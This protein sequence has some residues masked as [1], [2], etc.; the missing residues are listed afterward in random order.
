MAELRSDLGWSTPDQVLVRGR[1]LAADVLGRRSFAWT[2]FLH[3]TGREPTAGQ[4]AVFDA[5]L[6]TLLEHGLTPSAMVARLTHLGAP[7]ALQGAVA[8]GL[9]GLGDVFGGSAEA[10][11]AMLRE[12]RADGGDDP[13]DRGVAS[14]RAARRP[15][16]GIGH[17][18]HDPVDPRAE[19][20]WALAAEHGLDGWYVQTMKQIGEAASRAIGRHLPVNAT[21]AIGAL[22]CELDL[23]AGSERGLA[24]IGRAAGLVGHV[25][26]EQTTPIAREMWVRAERE[27]T[28]HALEEPPG[29]SA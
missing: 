25:L 12:A 26:E 15:V 17:P 19:R 9:L 14:R 16:P 1:D 21:G 28:Q 4:E 3:L 24:L 29:G 18:V 20:L 5:L 7:E 27:V 13:A 10:V 22:A 23:P 8:A 2:T 11:S 6:V